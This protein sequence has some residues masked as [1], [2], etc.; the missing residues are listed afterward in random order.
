MKIRVY[1]S[2]KGDCLLL[3]GH[4]KGRI[5]CDGGMQDSFSKFVAEQLV[6]EDPLDLVYVSHVDDDHITGILKLLDN[7]WAWRIF[8]HHRDQGD[9]DVQEPKVPKPPAIKRI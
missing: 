5:L 8:K 4:N 7:A 2:D 1:P 3:R 9:D 6:E